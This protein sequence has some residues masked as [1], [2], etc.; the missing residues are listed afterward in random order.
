MKKKMK[1]KC[2]K[3]KKTLQQLEMG[4]CPFESRYTVLYRD[5]KAGRLALLGERAV[6]RYKVCIITEAAYMAREVV[7]QY[8][9]CIV[10]GAEV[11]LGGSCVTIQEI[12]L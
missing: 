7:S 12:V 6:S 11:R 5:I 4:Y 10:I 3:K 8:T 2:E 9:W 1:K